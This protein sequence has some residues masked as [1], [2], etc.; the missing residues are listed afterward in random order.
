MRW[1]YL[2]NQA[3]SKLKETVD[4]KT[5][6]DRNSIPRIER[7]ASSTPVKSQG[8]SDTPGEGLLYLL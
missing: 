5:K 1:K 2:S 6:I 7:G 4:V 3:V 8:Y